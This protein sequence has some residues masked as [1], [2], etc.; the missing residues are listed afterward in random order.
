VADKRDREQ[1]LVDRAHE[2][3]QMRRQM[4]V[5]QPL[6]ADGDT[7]ERQHEGAGR[8]AI[9]EPEQQGGAA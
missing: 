7:R 9:R 1:R 4:V 5:E 3:D 2:R 8:R 6:K